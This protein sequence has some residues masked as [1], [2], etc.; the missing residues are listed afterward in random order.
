MGGVPWSDSH[1]KIRQTTKQVVVQRVNGLTMSDIHPESACKSAA[2]HKTTELLR[3]N[4]SASG[5]R[6]R[7]GRL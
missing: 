5:Y 7:W 4:N 3:S 2:Q 6:G 1:V